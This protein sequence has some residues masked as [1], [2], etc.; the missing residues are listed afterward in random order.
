MRVLC[1]AR[2]LEVFV[3]LIIFE[4]VELLSPPC[5]F[6]FK[7]SEREKQTVIAKF[8]SLI[9]DFI[10]ECFDLFKIAF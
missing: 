10:F 3:F 5:F 8:K 7:L 4:V 9:K 1:V 6:S 2:T